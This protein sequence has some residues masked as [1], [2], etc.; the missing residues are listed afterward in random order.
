M[1]SSPPPAAH[2]LFLRNTSLACPCFFKVWAP[3]FPFPFCPL[4]REGMSVLYRELKLK[5][6]CT[7]TCEKLNNYTHYPAQKF[8]AYKYS[9][10]L[11]AY[12][13]NLIA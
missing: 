5:E 9:A 7:T 8:C 13:R 4:L 10:F 3:F 12:L 2:L 1:S 6:Y 11:T